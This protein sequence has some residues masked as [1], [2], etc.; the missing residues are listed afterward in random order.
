MSAVNSFDL[1]VGRELG[2][3]LSEQFVLILGATNQNQPKT[4]AGSGIDTDGNKDPG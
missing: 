2:W 1:F 4:P 3:A